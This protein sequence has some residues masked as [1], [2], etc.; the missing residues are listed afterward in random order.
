MKKS[1]KIKSLLTVL[2]AGVIFLMTSCVSSDF[3]DIGQVGEFMETTGI[4]EISSVTSA[5]ATNLQT[6]G[7]AAEGISPEVEYYIGRSVAATILE[8]YKVYKN[9][10]VY[11]YLNK[12]CTTLAVNSDKPY[13]YKGYYIA[14]LDSDEINAISTPGGHILISKGLLKCATSEDALAGVIAHE[15]SHIQLG[16][17]TDVINTE[18]GLDVL[19]SS[20]AVMLAAKGDD[21][22]KE[23]VKNLND[24]S[25]SI[26]RKLLRSG[27]SQV[28]EFE[29]D[30]N[31]LKIMN[32]SGY[33]TYALLD[34]LQEIK[35]NAT[36]SGKGW[37]K[38]HPDPNLRIVEAKKQIQKS[39]Y[40]VVDMSPRTRRFNN[41]KAS[42]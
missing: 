30:S 23:D 31:A 20:L 37:E 27:F 18:R 34:M 33:N 1:L 14:V 6:I 17:S 41:F 24:T 36:H 13:L 12:I 3:S 5:V 9:Q 4:S 39:G 7:K 11:D 29:A 19:T 35:K 15:L 42:L 40:N 22:T 28:Q 26:A 10:K 21:F 25:D 16:H 32:N 38:T 2:S 8:E